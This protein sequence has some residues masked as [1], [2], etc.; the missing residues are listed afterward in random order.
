MTR[1]RLTIRNKNDTKKK[2]AGLGRQYY[3]D[4]YNKQKALPADKRN[5]SYFDNLKK[6]MQ[7]LDQLP[8]V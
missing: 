4:A 2:V 3:I 1:E 5:K 7:H 6:M 8:E